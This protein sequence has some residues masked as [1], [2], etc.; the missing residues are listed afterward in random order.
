MSYRPND[1]TSSIDTVDNAVNRMMNPTMLFVMKY[2]WNGILSVSL[3]GP[4]GLLHL[5]NKQ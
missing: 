1:Q 3:I 2:V 5:I 4:I